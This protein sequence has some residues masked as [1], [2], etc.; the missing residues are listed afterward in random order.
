M[1]LGLQTIDTGRR[2]GRPAREFTVELDREITVADLELLDT[3]PRNMTPTP[4][5][6]IT[7]R[8]HA[9]AR[10]LA[11]GMKDSDAAIVTGYSASRVSIL[12]SSP[13]FQELYSLYQGDV[14]ENHATILEHIAGV[15]RDVLLEI[16]DRIED[17]PESFSNRELLAILTETMDRSPSQ[18]DIAKFP[19]RI[20]LIA[21][22]NSTNSTGA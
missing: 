2:Q 5:K 21:Y 12:K 19:T 15:S 6:K 4:L 10:L 14:R 1:G 13:A 20:E 16:R 18:D 22:D 7:D 9:L 8:H 11:S 17:Q 3:T